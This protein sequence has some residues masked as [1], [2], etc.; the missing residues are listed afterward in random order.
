MMRNKAIFF[1][2]FSLYITIQA[3]SDI[4]TDLSH[5]LEKK[6]NIPNAFTINILNN[7]KYKDFII[8]TMDKPAEAL[9]W[10]K[11]KKIFLNKNK[12]NDGITFFK[13]NRYDV[14]E[15]A[16][17]F[18]FP[19]EILVSILGVESNYGKYNFSIRAVD[20]LCTLAFHY[21][22]RAKFFLNELEHFIVYSFNN[23]INPNT[24]MSSY[25]GAI[26]LPQFMPSSIIKYGY[27]YD[28]DSVV[29]LINSKKDALAS[30]ANYLT[31]KGWQNNMPVAVSI[32]LSEKN[33]D[34]ILNK[35]FTVDTLKSK[36]ITFTTPISANLSCK[37]VQ[38]DRDE[39]EY[40]YWATFN[41]YS[42][43]KSYNPS[44]KYALA[45]Y[46]LAKEIRKSF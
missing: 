26:G 43:L 7:Y 5:N 23:K 17:K 16:N 13:N 28:G 8:K 40:D 1:F 25:A 11:Y 33:V 35:T 6:H 31:K 30:I 29:D 42:V 44:N 45:V 4:K 14:M 37:I 36:N 19:P 39:N 22:R 3:H 15:V 10:N 46:L 9:P 21:E 20:A 41:N 38:I 12:I 24:I 27:D 18:N 34:N 2:F 32:K